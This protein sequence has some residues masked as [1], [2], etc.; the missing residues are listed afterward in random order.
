LPARRWLLVAVA[1]LL[2]APRPGWTD[3]GERLWRGLASGGHVALVRHAATEPGVGDPPGFRREDCA[4][5]RNLS[6][7]GRA[8]AV[9]LGETLRARGVRIDAVLSSDWCRCRETAAL[10]FGRY[11]PWPPLDSFF[12]DPTREPQQTRAV[13]D[14]IA[15]WRG[16]GALVLVTHQV[17]IAAA[18]GRTVGQGE[19]VVV[20]PDASGFE[21]LGVL[22]AVQ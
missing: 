1:A 3:T 20:R 5:Q 22:P 18:T 2:L 12:A 16:P 4:T 7:A 11:E 10:A 9:R 13:R 21:V 17:N 19:I 14:R 8:D 6:A 15:G